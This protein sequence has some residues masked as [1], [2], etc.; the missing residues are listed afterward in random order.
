MIVY[1]RRGRKILYHL[2][3][4]E[5][6]PYADMT[7]YY[8]SVT[9]TDYSADSGAKGFVRVQAELEFPDGDTGHLDGVEYADAADPHMLQYFTASKVSASAVTIIKQGRLLDGGAI[10]TVEPDILVDSSASTGGDGSFATP[11]DE[12]ADLSLSGGEIIALASDSVFPETLTLPASTSVYRYGAGDKPHIFGGETFP[13]SWSA[14]GGYTNIYDQAVTI[15][16]HSSLSFVNVREDGDFLVR[17]E[18]L[19]TC[20]STAGSIYVAS[21]SG[22]GDTSVTV[23]IHASDSGNPNSNGKVY[24][25]ARR[26]KSIDC[27]GAG[28]VIDGIRTSFTTHDNGS[29]TLQGTLRNSDAEFGGKH[30]IYMRDNSQAYNVLTL[31][32]YY[33]PSDSTPSRTLFVLNEDDPSVGGLLSECVGLSD[34]YDEDLT[35]MLSHSNTGP[36]RFATTTLYRCYWNLLNSGCSG[37][38]DHDEA[39]ISKNVCLDCRSGVSFSYPDSGSGGGSVT[40][41]DNYIDLV[42]SSIGG[43]GIEVSYTTG[44]IVISNNTI[45]GNGSIMPYMISASIGGDLTVEDNKFIFDGSTGASRRAIQLD[46]YLSNTPDTVTCNRNMHSTGFL[47]YYHF[48]KTPGAFVAD[49]NCFGADGNYFYDIGFGS[50]TNIAGW[51]TYTGQEANSTVGGCV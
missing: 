33:N 49:Y 9:R 19:A 32:A 18:D 20:D 34:V 10:T 7:Q 1:S 27:D 4:S 41:T 46:S 22:S 29:I 26:L 3:G 31:N 11:Y 16:L 36:G 51:R 48:L 13:A 12:L 43:A 6:S 2:M 47:R 15:E 17:V 8:T 14:T 39:I 21:D 28:C 38:R 5:A 42:D 45:Y 44:S 24:D 30:N 35:G 25:Y 50:T 40:I 23:Y 37:L